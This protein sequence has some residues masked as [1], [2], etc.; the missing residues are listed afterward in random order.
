MYKFISDSPI[1]IQIANDIISQIIGG[2][3]TSG[4]RVS[5]V[6][7]LAQYYSVNPN[8]IQKAMKHLEDEKLII[9]ERGIGRIVGSQNKIN[10]FK[11]K[12][13]KS[14]VAKFVK[15][16][17]DRGVKKEDLLNLLEEEWGHED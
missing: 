17:I 12:Y 7:D 14:E 10:K 5:S 11:D 15:A 8:T 1:F 6:R 9:V 3:I 16:S 4:E 13:I 2:K